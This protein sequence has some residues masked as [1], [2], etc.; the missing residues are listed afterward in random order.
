MI[1]A[2]NRP[3]TL[4]QWAQIAILAVIPHQKNFFLL[5]DELRNRVDF[6]A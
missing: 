6:D 3:E 1:T 4:C 5:C 2:L